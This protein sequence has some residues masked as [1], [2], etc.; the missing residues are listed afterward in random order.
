[1]S[2]FTRIEHSELAAFLTRYAVGS[3][4]SFSGI[5]SGIE[6]TNYFVTTDRGEYVLTIF[7]TVDRADLPFFLG[8]TAFLAEHAIPCAHP[9][10][11]SEGSYIGS[12]QGKAAALVV[13]LFGGSVID[14]GVAHCAA[15]GHTL[16]SLHKAAAGFGMSRDNPRGPHWWRQA[17]ESLAGKLDPV[18]A[19]C[20]REELRFQ[21]LYRFA[22]LPRG[23]IHADLFRD[24]AL[25]DG[26]RIAGVIDFYYACSDTWL[27]DLAITVNDWCSREN[28]HLDFARAGSLVDAYQGIRP[29][30]AMERGAWPTMLRAAALRFWLSRLRDLHFPRAGELTHTKDPLVFRRILDARRSETA[31]LRNMWRRSSVNEANRP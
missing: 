9:L 24:N 18:D 4:V 11:D 26:D 21:T 7:E 1:M 27:Y 29:L 8:L 20:L 5:E 31:R 17:A 23:V 25:F 3:L 12:L 13:R 14:P 30:T 22:D 2:V 15:I 16:G 6:N 10:R 19:D 28:G